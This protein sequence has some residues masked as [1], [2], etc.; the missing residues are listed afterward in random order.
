MP[1][2]KKRPKTAFVIRDFAMLEQYARKFAEGYFN[3][4]ILIGP[5]GV[6]KSQTVKQAIG[7]RALRIEGS[8]S[9]FGIYCSLYENRD[10]PIVIDDVDSLYTDRE[11][12]RL[13]KCV[14]QTDPV[15][16]VQWH[17]GAAG[18]GKDVPREFETTSKVIIIANEWKTLSE[19]VRAVENRG[20]LLFFEP[21]AAEVHLKVAEWFWDQEVYDFFGANLHLLPGLSMRHYVQ[22]AELKAAGMEWLDILHRE[23]FAEKTVLVAK[24]KNDPQYRT[25][26]E[27]IAAFKEQGGGGRSTY[28]SHA[29]KLIGKKRVDV[30]QVKLKRTRPPAAK[31]QFRVVGE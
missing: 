24:V 18:K 7:D 20:H 1:I 12:V 2:S 19:N 17:T 23:G 10:R 8:A 11:C 3:L 4:L 31:P 26:N 28:F 14:C 15:K 27:R 25:E 6:A 29:K 9:A 21:T 5:A 16:L 30:P 13:L 22:A